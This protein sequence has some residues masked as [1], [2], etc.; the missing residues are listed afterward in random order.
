MPN[1]ASDK[2]TVSGF[3]ADLS[4]S[5]QDLANK[6]RGR[7]DLGAV[8]KHGACE[9][10]LFNSQ[11][12]PE[13]TLEY[14][15]QIGGWFAVAS[16]IKLGG[17]QSRPVG[18]HASA[19]E[20]AAGEKGNGA[21]AVVRSVSAV[22]ARGAS[23]LRDDCDHCLAPGF[24]YVGLDGCQRAV[25]SSQQIGKLTGGRA[26]VDVR[27]PSDKAH[28]CAGGVGEIGTHARNARRWKRSAVGH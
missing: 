25:E 18:D 2:M 13:Q 7:H 4:I 6:T 20:C 10:A 11:V 3:M 5:Q 1:I 27:I 24:A 8:G 26:L 14:G 21:R 9:H 22:D 23:E 15:A 17:L 28:R 19:P 16:L 12:I